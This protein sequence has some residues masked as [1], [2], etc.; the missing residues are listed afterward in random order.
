MLF[1]GL[2]SFVLLAD[3]YPLNIYHETRSG[4]Y[5]LRLPITEIIL[6]ICLWSLLIEE[7]QQV[8]HK[9]KKF[10]SISFSCLIILTADSYE[11]KKRL[12]YWRMEHP[13]YGRLFFVYRRLHYTI[14]RYWNT[15]YNLK[16]SHARFKLY[17][18]TRENVIWNTVTFVQ[19]SSWVL[20]W[21]FGTF[22]SSIYSPLMNESDHS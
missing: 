12:F 5:D 13:W 17:L 16:V 2:F 22:E 6:H 10:F 3:Y 1:L 7:I 9:Q 18:V 21:S 20:I 15:I 8:R 11:V 4:S 14:H 19:E